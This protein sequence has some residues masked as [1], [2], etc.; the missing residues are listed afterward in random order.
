MEKEIMSLDEVAEYLG[1]EYQF[2]YRAVR[3]GTL[4]SIRLGRI[5][6]VR[7]SD[8]QRYLEASMSPVP[9]SL[10]ECY[11]CGRKFNSPSSVKYRCASADCGRGIC[12]DCFERLNKRFCFEHEPK[13]NKESAE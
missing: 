6:R 13:K 9:Q 8:L 4:P 12:V 3:A 2:V 1:V 5:Y 10:I 11:S 7:F